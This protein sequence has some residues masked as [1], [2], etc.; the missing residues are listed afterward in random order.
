MSCY[1]TFSF[2]SIVFFYLMKLMIDLIYILIFL[3]VVQ[4][5]SNLFLWRKSKTKKHRPDS[6]ELS[7]FLFDLRAGGALLHVKRVDPADVV[8]RSPRGR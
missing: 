8:I 2:T 7:E 5:A 6:V 1:I 4:G 3:N